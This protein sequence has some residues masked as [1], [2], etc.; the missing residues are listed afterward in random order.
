MIQVIQGISHFISHKNLKLNPKISSQVRIIKNKINSKIFKMSTSHF[1]SK[2]F[3]IRCLNK[4][5]DIF[6][7]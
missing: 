7:L 1:F 4:N 6:F 5:M 2:Q 3:R